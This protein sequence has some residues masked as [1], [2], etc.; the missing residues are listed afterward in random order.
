MEPTGESAE[1]LYE[2]A[3]CGY[4]STLPDG[5][6][7]KVNETF[8]RW[9]GHGR[10]EIVA[11]KRF[12]DLL[13]AGGRIYHET[14]IAPLLRMQGTV[15][16]IA[17]EVVCADGRRL[18]VVISSV[19]KRDADGN[20]LLIRTAMF[21]ATER[22]QYER[23]L[24]RARDRERAARERTERLQR[25]TAALAGALAAEQIGA[26]IVPELLGSAGASRA[27][28]A[29]LDGGGEQLEIVTRF[30][31]EDEAADAWLAE[32]RRPGSPVRSALESAEPVF[33]DSTEGSGAIAVLPLVAQA[34]SRGVVWLGF[35]EAREFA[36]AERAFMAACAGQCTQALERAQLQERTFVVARRTAMLA[37]A[38]RA[39]DEVQGFDERAQRL[40]E[41]VAEHVGSLAWIELLADE[42]PVAIAAADRA[43]TPRD[44]LLSRPREARLSARAAVAAGQALATREPRVVVEPGA[45]G[46]AG[47]H[48]Y[49]ALPLRARGRVLGMLIV[50]RFDP[51][52][53]FHDGD[54]GFLAE[55]ADR[56]A[57]ALENARLYEQQR[58]VA[59]VLQQSL[60]AG[61]PPRDARF[62]VATR[63]RSPIA[64]L[65]VG[66]DWYD[67]FTTGESRIGVVVGDVVGRGIVAASA[68]GQ[69]RSAVRAVATA[70]LRPAEVL[71]RLDAF[72]AQNE[73]ARYATVA[74]ADV[75]LESGRARL[76]CAGHPPP[77]LAAPGRP[78]RIVWDGRSPPL[79]A[80]HRI[81]EDAE[82]A[83][84]PG[85][86][87]L[88]YTDGLVERPG[89]LI[90]DGLDR[91]VDE[92]EARR[93]TPLPALL[94][95][96]IDAMGVGGEHRD[97][98][99]LLCLRLSR[100]A[101]TPAAP[102]RA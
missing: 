61:A 88:L 33:A 100:P 89:E 90:D 5:T 79:G 91:L 77:V 71:D 98:V 76:A 50:A 1:D 101:R 51:E 41:L 28:F 68:M 38:S 75:D 52:P 34:R 48:S 21:D 99:C 4:L 84:P 23:E 40:L 54:L 65:E 58:E 19:L 20:P 86:R 57:L 47:A 70:G 7:T 45:A 42:Q 25:I 56:A 16:E 26:A 10:D 22:K 66:G 17:L 64:T 81:R 13:S 55:L 27:V 74:Y 59:H 35:P 97:D 80:G 67:T 30:G 69:L 18:P 87:L 72:V 15:R 36:D 73:P 92:F 49:V 14:H 8:L 93:E 6:I 2:H 11:R 63:Y 62:E 102:R 29:V 9:T 96:V 43:G 83:L 60:L 53:R 31:I 82:I 78:S 3:P 32:A 46:P 37:H 94:D 39:L 24:L 12:P 85:A 95:D 44:A